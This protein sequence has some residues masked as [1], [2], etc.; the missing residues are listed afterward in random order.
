MVSESESMMQSEPAVE[1]LEPVESTEPVSPP[2]KGDKKKLWIMIVAI[3]VVAA[4]IGSAAFVLVS[5]NKLKVTMSPDEIPDMPAGGAQELSV[6]VKWGSSTVD[7]TD[8]VT[9]SWS[10]SPS[11]LGEFDYEARA[12]VTFEAGDSEGEGTITCEVTYEG[13]TASVEADIVVDPPFLDTVN[14][15]PSTKTLLPD[16]EW[17]FNATAVNSVGQ[18]VSD[19]TF[20]WSVSG[21]DVGDYT[22]SSTTGSTV[23]FSCAVEANV[24]LT[25]VGTSGDESATGTSL[26]TVTYDIA[27]RTVDTLWYDMFGHPLGPWYA[28]RLF[29]YGDEWAITD[30]FPYMY[31]WAGDPIGN[32]WIYTNARMNITALN[33]DSSELSMNDNPEYLPYLSGPDGARGGNAELDWYMNYVTL[34]ECYGKL[35]T[36]SIQYYDGWY[37]ELN[38]TISLDKQAAKSVLG[39]TDS[40]FDA[41]DAWWATDGSRIKGEWEDWLVEEAGNDRLAIFNAYEYYL[42]IVYMTLDAVKEGDQIVLTLDSISWGME[43]L[44]FRWMRESFLPT[45]WY[46]E[47]MNLN[48]RIGPESGDVHL[49]TAVGYA[50]YAYE[51]TDVAGA[52]CWAWEALVQDYVESTYKY[53]IS[54]FDVYADFTYY[55]LAPGSDWYGDDMD[56]DYTPIAW[57]LSAGETL[58]LEWPDEEIVFF[59]HDENSTADPLESDTLDIIVNKVRVY[60]ALPTCTYAEPMPSDNAE[61]ISIDTDSRRV[62]YTGPFDMWD[63]SKTQVAHEWLMDEWDRLGLLP[64]GAPYV[65]FRADV[66]EPL[67]ELLLEDVPESVEMG[68]EFS[69]NVTITDAVTGDPITDYTGTVTFSSSDLAATLPADT[70][71]EASDNGRREFTATFNTVDPVSH[72]ATHYLTAVDTVDSSLSDTVSGIYVVEIPILSS[73]DVAFED[74]T[75]IALEPTDV[76]V[77]ALNQWDEAFTDYEGTVN[78]TSS[79]DDAELPPNTTYDPD[80]DGVMTFSVTYATAGAQTLNATD[81]DNADAYG[82]DTIIVWEARAADHYVVS[83]LAE[84][85]GA[86]TTITVNV[87]IEDQYDEEFMA[88]GGTMEV[89]SNNSD[90]F[91]EP[92]LATFTPGDPWVEVELN[93]TSQG[94]F[95]VNFTD[96]VDSTINA[97]LEVF[98][99]DSK[100]VIHHFEVTGITD[101][102]ENNASDVTVTAVNQYDSV[103]ESYAGT[104]V[105]S[106]NATSGATLPTTGLTF[107][108]V[109][110]KG[111]KTYEDGVTFA[112]PGVFNVTVSD[113]SDTTINGTQEDIDIEDL[114]AT[115]I[116]IESSV[117]AI[118]ENVTFSLEVT[119][120]HREGWVFEE[121]DGTVDF[122]STDDSGYATLPP[123]YKF[124]PS[125]DAGTHDFTDSISLSKIGLQTV[126]VEDVANSLTDS[127]GVEVSPVVTSVLDY[128]IYDLFGEDWGSWWTVRVDSAWDTDRAL[129]TG[130]GSMTY[131]YDAFDDGSMG[132]IYAPYRWNFTGSELPNLNVHDPMFM[133]VVDDTPG[134]QAGAIATVDIYHQY[135]T[136]TWWDDYWIPTWNTNWMWESSFVTL[137]DKDDGWFSGAL[138]NVTMNRAAALEWLGMP[139]DA[140]PSDWWTANRDEYRTDWSG[141]IL[142]QGNEVYDIF[143]GYDYAYTDMIGGALMDLEGDADEVTLRIG[144]VTWGFE[145]LM[146]RW[147]AASELS[148]H[149]AYLEDMSLTLEYTGAVVNASFDAVV[150]WNM[151]SVRQNGSEPATGA[152]CAFAWTPTHLDYL[153]KM[154]KTSAYTPYASLYYE[155]LNCGDPY[156]GTDAPYEYTP[157]QFTLPEYG[158][159]TIELPDDPVPG[160]YAQPVASDAVDDVFKRN[161]FSAYEPLKYTGEI[162]LGYCD[163][164]LAASSDWDPDAKTL[165]IQGPWEPV[166]PNPLDEDLLLTGAPWIEFN[167]DP[168]TMAASASSGMPAADLVPAE[169]VTVGESAA[170]VS[171]SVIGEL[172]SMASIISAA[173]LVIAALAIN[174]RRRPVVC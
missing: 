153:E 128:R 49:D 140:T 77:T 52:S 113:A 95:Y 73:F 25:A 132:V 138:I 170:S 160:Y 32:T 133:Y 81:V 87:T 79:D 20:A 167:V 76:T 123:S 38:G 9:Y 159:L 139:T 145:A 154:G 55:N 82:E 155:S 4:L 130:A 94:S 131:L 67:P 44:M 68:E 110:D 149:Q 105:F 40:Q 23:T 129:T 126:T 101:M 34:E 100:P 14:I 48:V 42:D 5:G 27:D 31:I 2:R 30:E 66:D 6:E 11:T 103:F 136:P 122:S 97:S 47:D 33:L 171:A 165:V 166:S 15:V 63:W 98:A 96:T 90:E 127:V 41:F 83:G 141:W 162:T 10:V 147:L 125:S 152:P 56:W 78:F 144:H 146:T 102:W 106:T 29:N 137:M 64:Y 21:A 8:G 39:I 18:V 13:K 69:F 161:D 61:L 172:A 135:L 72:Q 28:D 24:T 1:E 91:T 163:L 7:S 88:Y 65:E 120:Y 57:N 174:A 58:T 43:A 151:K 3:I 35:G 16:A 62:T 54:M 121:Y 70:E 93:F 118:V 53:P 157:I 46:M 111:V 112:D 51:A 156:Y 84:D 80:D 37:V 22:L 89:T 115:I 109:T 150:Q 50:M 104:I 36:Q 92:G 74:D 142:D 119:V 117:S 124:E 60:E 12:S 99:W 85:V 169:P 108:P 143:C 75:V 59:T 148:V 19:A 173:V 26:V 45:E 164:S 168:T 134:A 158:T 114:V 107:N 86:N 71:F 116:E 17:D